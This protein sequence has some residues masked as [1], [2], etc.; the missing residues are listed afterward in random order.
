MFGSWNRKLLE[1]QEFIRKKHKSGK[2]FESGIRRPKLVRITTRIFLHAKEVPQA[3]ENQHGNS[4]TT[5]W[6]KKMFDMFGHE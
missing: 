5:A 6:I 4:E 2:V 1:D 3:V